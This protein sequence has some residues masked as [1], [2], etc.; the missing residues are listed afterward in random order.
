[1][2]KQHRDID[3]EYL[4][5]RDWSYHLLEQE[6][7]NDFEHDVLMDILYHVMGDTPM[8]MDQLRTEIVAMLEPPVSSQRRGD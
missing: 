4:D 7:S 3:G 6:A 2:A 8:T 1:M 5:L